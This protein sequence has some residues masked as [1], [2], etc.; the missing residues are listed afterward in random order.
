MGV[1]ASWG[2]KK[3]ET[4]TKKIYPLS[5]FSTEFKLKSDANS[6]TSG[7]SPVNTR[8][9]ELEQITFSSRILAAAGINVRGEFGSW[10]KLV[11][12]VHPLIIGG[13]SFG[14]GNFQLESVSISETV[15]DLEGNF[16]A[17]TLSFTFSE[18]IAANA[19]ATA[20]ATTTSSSKGTSS[21][22]SG[23]SKS[24]S[25]STTTAKKS[26]TANIEAKKK[27][28][29]NTKASSADKGRKTPYG[30]SIKGVAKL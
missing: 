22:K 9:R 3:F 14:A 26:M 12:E 18:Y 10:R 17:A 30:N 15:L 16:I 11:G 28:A 1:I 5:D 7:T 23:S 2:T 29:L 19:A 6:D 25:K 27:E 21:A 24:T 20:K 13:A 4:T 8:G